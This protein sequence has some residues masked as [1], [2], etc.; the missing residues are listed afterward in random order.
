MKLKLNPLMKHISLAAPALALGLIAFSPAQAV[1]PEEGK[2]NYIWQGFQGGA[3]HTGHIPVSIVV[4]NS[5]TKV[6]GWPMYAYTSNSF[7]STSEY[8]I[9]HADGAGL[10]ISAIPYLVFHQKLNQ[11]TVV[12]D[13]VIVTNRGYLTPFYVTHIDRD[14]NAATMFDYL[15]EE[16]DY[17]S[18]DAGDYLADEYCTQ[19]Q[20][21]AVYVDDVAYLTTNYY[22]LSS[23]DRLCDPYIDI[24]T[25][26]LTHL[27]AHAI[28]PDK[29]SSGG[30]GLEISVGSNTMMAIEAHHKDQFLSPVYYDGSIYSQGG[31]LTSSRDHSGV[32]SVTN[33][34]TTSSVSLTNN[35][36]SLND[37]GYVKVAPNSLWAP[38]VNASQVI[39]FL[40]GTTSDDYD[41]N[42]PTLTQIN[43]TAGTTTQQ[44]IDSFNFIA[45]QETSF[46]VFNMATSPVLADENTLVTI[47]N[48]NLLFFDVSQNT[49][50]AAPTIVNGGFYGQPVVA[51]DVVYAL[52][53]NAGFCAS[54]ASCVRAISVTSKA[55][56]KDSNGNDWVWLPPTST[57]MLSFP[58]V[59][60]NSHIFLSS[61]ADNTYGVDTSTSILNSARLDMTYPLGG[62]LAFSYDTLYI[63]HSAADNSLSLSANY[64]DLKLSRPLMN[65]GAVST[66]NSNLASTWATHNSDI[67]GFTNTVKNNEAS[68]VVALK[69]PIDTNFAADLD[70]DLAVTAPSANATTAEVDQIITY[71]ATVTNNGVLDATNVTATAIIPGAVQFVEGSVTGDVSCSLSGSLLTCLVDGDTADAESNT[72]AVSDS[73]PFSFS[74]IPQVESVITM[75]VNVDGSELNPDS[76]ASSDD[77]NSAT[78]EMLSTPASP[79]SHDIS[80]TVTPTT[81]YTVDLDRLI[82]YEMTVTN[83]ESSVNTAIDV[84]LSYAVANS[85][86]E[87]IADF[88]NCTSSNC[89]ISRLDPGASQTF[90]IKTRTIGAGQGG[91]TASATSTRAEATDTNTANNSAS[92]TNTQVT[93]I[94]ST[95][96]PTELPKAS[97]SWD[98]LL[99]LGL[100][101][102]LFSRKR[103]KA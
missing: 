17:T 49:Y 33:T 31:G 62:E 89:T 66:L 100:G 1:T 68:V 42:I 90:T 81:D 40:N 93:D 24:P 29:T 47:N 72:L 9:M 16:T 35:W 98:W 78:V 83:A 60:T 51:G 21:Q 11:P 52:S 32:Y 87:T 41:D 75:T 43:R 86:V 30:Q 59:A 85:E 88:G 3:S 26:Q 39:T 14:T 82:T 5:P 34:G 80:V 25:D 4:D 19:S 99:S 36:S 58:F 44:Q 50:I 6:E 56:L 74:V 61:D 48:G 22:K 92:F 37:E 38:A 79:S 94:L 15:S 76:D 20:S 28:R 65:A 7:S 96:D 8:S 23:E 103:K 2:A 57:E 95:E 101:S 53:K 64:P 77:D 63:A 45:T 27:R 91:I 18:D 71:Q 55:P 102:L 73:V 70:V 97:G 67:T 54:S 12:E 10:D 46:N 13:A 84:R 69:F